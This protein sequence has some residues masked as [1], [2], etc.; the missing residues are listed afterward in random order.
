[1]LDLGITQVDV[2]RLNLPYSED[3]YYLFSSRTDTSFDSTIVYT[4]TNTVL[5]G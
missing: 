4:T 2:F 1:M 5:Q 3:T